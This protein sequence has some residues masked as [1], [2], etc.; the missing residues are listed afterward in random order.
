MY[1]FHSLQRNVES[2]RHEPEKWKIGCSAFVDHVVGFG[3]FPR[4]LGDAVVHGCNLLLLPLS[5]FL[6]LA[7]FTH[8][9]SLLKTLI[10]PCMYTMF[11][12]REDLST[13]V[14]ACQ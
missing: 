9:H 7:S 12:T 5:L 1:A 4:G 6:V 8:I 3:S 14:H 2:P 10:G 11:P 13:G